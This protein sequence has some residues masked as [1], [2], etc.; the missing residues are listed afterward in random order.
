MRASDCEKLQEALAAANLVVVGASNGLDMAEGLN[1]FAADGHFWEAYGDLAQITGA[2]SIL[3][4]LWFSQSDAKL[5]WA[6]QSRF[7]REEWLGYQSS[8]L[9]K[10]IAA[11]TGE[12]ERFVLTCNVDGHFV[13]SGFD[14]ANLLETEGTV[15]QMVCSR[16]CM[17][18]RYNTE[19]LLEQAGTPS[20]AELLSGVGDNM[21]RC[22]L[23]GAPLVLAIDEQ[24]LDHPDA[25]CQTALVRFGECIDR[26]RGGRIVV[27]ELGVGRRNGVIKEQLR[28]IACNEPNATY[29]VFNY[30]EAD[31][32]MGLEDRCFVFEGDM[33]AAFDE[34]VGGCR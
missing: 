31:I 11:L 19:E 18:R 33:A 13:R 28:R 6:W 32:P 1:I 22:P 23:C 29:A 27:L 15:R 16:H 2:R 34:L 4:G 21:P 3:E 10:K 20:A 24:R 7:A 9:M 8:T 17:P 5:H 26:H 14:P 25:S 30:N 12:A